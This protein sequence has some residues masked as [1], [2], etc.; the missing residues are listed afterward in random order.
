MWECTSSA[1]PMMPS[2]PG[3]S[4]ARVSTMKFGAPGALLNSGSPGSSGMKTVPLLALLSIWSRP[5]SKNWPKNVK[6]LLAGADRP[7]S[8]VMLGMN[9]LCPSPGIDALLLDALV[10]VV[11]LPNDT[12]SSA[13]PRM[14]SGPG[15]RVPV[16]SAVP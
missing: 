5:W 3:R 15:T 12:K 2:G 9:R 11:V 8:G 1:V 6:K 7:A 14:P 4:C 10:G 16:S 13:V